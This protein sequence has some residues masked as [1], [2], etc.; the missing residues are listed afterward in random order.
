[1]EEES[2]YTELL[3]RLLEYIEDEST[4][5]LYY[6]ELAKKAHNDQA[7]ELILE[8]GAD[9]AKH[10]EQFKQV[11]LLIA[12]VEPELK[13]I[14]TPKVPSYC[15]AVKYRILPESNDFVKYGQEYLDAPDNELKQLFYLTGA[16]EAKHGMRLSSLL[17]ISEHHKK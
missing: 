12:G 16:E 17:C 14:E 13:P 3:G 4:D 2:Y 8:F 11:Y 15:E 1:M 10:A 5:A 9:E 7:K 6:Q